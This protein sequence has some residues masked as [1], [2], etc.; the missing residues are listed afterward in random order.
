MARGELLQKGIRSERLQ[1]HWEVC[2]IG[3]S[4]GVSSE[5]GNMALNRDY[6]RSFHGA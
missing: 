2:L 4:N 3:M 1:S 6:P 5:R